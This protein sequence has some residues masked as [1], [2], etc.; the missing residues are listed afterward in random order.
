MSKP[1]FVS[2]STIKMV[3]TDERDVAF[4]NDNDGKSF[5]K[6]QLPSGLV[7]PDEFWTVVG[8]VL[9]KSAAL[10]P[11]CKD[12][13]MPAHQCLCSHGDDECDESC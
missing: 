11:K 10:F 1:E 9:V 4:L 8:G 5:K 7:T 13:F 12:C 6:H 2:L 3:S